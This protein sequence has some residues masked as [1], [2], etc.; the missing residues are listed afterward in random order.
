MCKTRNAKVLLAVFLF[1]VCSIFLTPISATQQHAPPVQT[2]AEQDDMINIGDAIN[3]VDTMLNGLYEINSILRDLMHVASNSAYGSY[4]NIQRALMNADFQTWMNEIDLAAESTE[5][6]G[7]KM[8]DGLI[9]SV[10]VRQMRKSF[11]ITGVDMTRIGLG[12]DGNNLDISTPQSARQTMELLGEAIAIATQAE[13]T[14]IEEYFIRLRHLPMPNRRIDR[15]DDDLLSIDEGMDIIQGVIMVLGYS[16]D[17]ISHL[18][19]SAIHSSL[20]VF[21]SAQMIIMD[22]AFHEYLNQI[23]SLVENMGDY[24]GFG[25]LNSST[26]SMTIRLNRR[27]QLGGIKGKP[28]VIEKV[29]VTLAGL[30]LDR[31]DLNI[32]TIQAAEQA[33]EDLDEARDLLLSIGQTYYDYIIYLETSE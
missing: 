28:L 7:F 12:L 19:M 18:K 15:Q 22:A 6:N 33:I 13:R 17:N 30:G 10:A 27:P 9:E 4:S 16:L 29:D 1:C 32:R 3:L 21:S 31:E 11:R 2:A 5:Y 8:L 14:C 25:M 24:L 26:G 20:G 23:D